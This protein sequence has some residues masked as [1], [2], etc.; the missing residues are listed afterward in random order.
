MPILEATMGILVATMP[1]L[2]T[3]TSI[4]AANMSN[5]GKMLYNIAAKLCYFRVKLA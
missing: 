5:L 1:I 4:Q 3:I 2:E